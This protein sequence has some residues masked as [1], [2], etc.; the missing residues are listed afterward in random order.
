MAVISFL[1]VNGT[2]TLTL[3]S[4]EVV[5]LENPSVKADASTN[6]VI[7]HENGRAEYF[8]PLSNSITV[9]GVAFNGTASQLATSLVNSVFNTTVGG[10]EVT[11]EQIIAAIQSLPGYAANKGLVVNEAGD[12]LEFVNVQ[13]NVL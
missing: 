11:T 12:G 13:I 1:K 10:G 9:N 3:G 8:I 6:Q 2:P 5:S 4:G 7:I